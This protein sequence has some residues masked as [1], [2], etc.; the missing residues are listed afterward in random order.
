MS[1]SGLLAG[2]WP[3]VVDSYEADTRT[4][5]VSIPGITDGAETGLVAEIEYPVGDKSR[6]ETMTEIEIL[7]G[8]LVWVEFIQGDPRFPLITGW[9]NPTTGN[10]A[11]WRRWHHANM[12][13]LTDSEMRLHSGGLVHVSAGDSITLQ[14]GGSTITLTPDDITQ[15]SSMINL[16]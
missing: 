12:Q 15:L 10:S 14:V 9:R 4:C 6:H 2:K 8:D 13:L 1:G 16:N 11:G 7:P 3:A 5:V